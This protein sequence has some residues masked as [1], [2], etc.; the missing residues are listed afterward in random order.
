MSYG[1][2]N[3]IGRS[4]IKGSAIM[5]RK[6]NYGR[7]AL[8]IMMGI[9]ALT[10]LLFIG[11]DGKRSDNSDM[12]PVA[13]PGVGA[14]QEEALLYEIA[15]AEDFFQWYA[16][17][18]KYDDLEIQSAKL[19][20]AFTEK[21]QMLLKN[22][23]AKPLGESL[24]LV[25]FDWEMQGTNPGA[26]N[27]ATFNIS[28]LFYKKAPIQTDGQ[29]LFL[30]LRGRVDGAHAKF[31]KVKPYGDNIIEKTWTFEYSLEEWPE[32][33]YLLVTRS[34]KVPSI[35]YNML[36]WLIW[37]PTTGSNAGILGEQIKLGWYV[38][39]GK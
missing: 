32:N 33:D 38:D 9:I 31:L 26:G 39:L 28:W 35:P 18:E 17:R 11:C 5:M 3:I 16:C 30:V 15:S 10:G 1:G 23:P 14:S 7:D 12:P 29:K 8:L 22:E 4:A 25:A 37:D 6:N 19:E 27:E 34:T 21:E 36:T 13:T 24:E 20:A 2:I